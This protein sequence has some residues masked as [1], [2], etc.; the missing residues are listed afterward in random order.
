MANKF[1]INKSY[2][3]LYEGSL[4]ASSVKQTIAELNAYLECTNKRLNGVPYSG[5]IVYCVENDTTYLI[6]KASNGYIKKPIS[7]Q[8]VFNDDNTMNAYLASGKCYDGQIIY[9]RLQNKAFLIVED[10]TTGL[11]R[12]QG[13]GSTN[14][15]VAASQGPTGPAGPSYYDTW[16]SIP[17][18]EGKTINQMIVE[19]VGATGESGRAGIN[20]KSAFE[21]WRETQP[22]SLNK[23][24]ANFFEAIRGANGSEGPT[25]PKGLSAFEIWKIQQDMP[26]AS[27]ADFL[28][29]L[30]GKQGPTGEQGPIGPKGNDGTSVQILGSYESEDA[31]NTYEAFGGVGDAYLVGGLLYVWD[32]NNKRW[33]NVGRMQGPTG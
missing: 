28:M 21:V 9:N 3:R 18:N 33:K 24:E 16:V 10:H 26:N 4:D 17:G 23:T 20:G 29:A 5:Q 7:V 31:L 22:D 15:D 13:I 30:R 12:I 25:G 6:N 27:Q 14:G 11:F 19:H 32:A 2:D 1:S 8:V